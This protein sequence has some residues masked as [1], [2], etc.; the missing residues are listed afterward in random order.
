[1]Y[2]GLAYVNLGIVFEKFSADNGFKDFSFKQDFTIEKLFD[3]WAIGFNFLGKTPKTILKFTLSLVKPKFSPHESFI[4]KNGTHFCT[5]A[6][7]FTG[8]H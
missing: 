5:N 1:M 4:K 7:E 3:F 2:P 8:L 6:I